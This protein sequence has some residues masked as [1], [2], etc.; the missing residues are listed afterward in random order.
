MIS[1]SSQPIT[2]TN[3]A[4][5]SP[6]LLIRRLIARKTNPNVRPCLLRRQ[7]S[8]LLTHIQSSLP[9]TPTAWALLSLAV[10]SAVLQ[11]ELRLQRLLSVP[12]DVFCDLLHNKRMSRIYKKLSREGGIFS[13]SVVPSLFVGTRGVVSSMAAYALKAGGTRDDTKTKVSR[14]REVMTMGADGAKILLDWE[15]PNTASS[16]FQSSHCGEINKIS[17]I[18][19][20]VVLL[21]HGMNNDSSFGYIRSM[22]KTATSR[23]WVAVC[24]NL[25]GQDG[26]GEVK[27]TT[28]RGVSRPYRRFERS[29]ITVGEKATKENAT[30]QQKRIGNSRIHRRR[31][32]LGNPLHIAS[33][34]IRFP[35]NIILAMGVKHSLL[36]NFP[37]YSQHHERGFQN[38]MKKAMLSR[39]I[40]QLDDACAPYILRNEP[41]PPYAPR[42]GYKNG[43]EYWHDSSSHRYV[44]HVSV[45]LLKVAAK[46]DFLVFGQFSRKLNHC[47]ENP[48]VVVV[49]TQCDGHLGWQESPPPSRDT[50][51]K[52]SAW[53]GGGIGSW[54]DVAVADFIEAL[55]E[56]RNEDRSREEIRNNGRNEAVSPKLVSKL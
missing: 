43:K 29:S 17:S 48:N 52:A 4:R 56:T 12:P 24:M 28:P 5:I 32:A 11:H 7:S 9:T 40:G 22:M 20:P 49:K 31:T 14:I 18:A 2:E 47:L 3:Q 34:S 10:S 36:Q 35:W 50:D 23:G 38:A 15:I 13:Q 46:D 37:V 44:G 54:S 1:T 25:R 6:L 30:A 21:V 41:N 33:N 51:G 19:Q 39:T 45:P 55:L 26:M 16:E 27:N 42:L 53:F 8:L